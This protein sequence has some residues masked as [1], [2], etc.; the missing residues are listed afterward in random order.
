MAVSLVALVIALGGAGIAATGGNFILGN[1]NSALT[2][3]ALQGPIGT[4]TLQINNGNTTAGATALALSVQTGHPPMKVN[5]ATRVANLNADRVDNLS[6]SD[7][8]R[9]ATGTMVFPGG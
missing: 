9:I 6:P 5:S 8:S 3:T 2:P 7:F 4:R 1:T